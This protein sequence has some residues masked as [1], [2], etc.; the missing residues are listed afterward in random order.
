[1]K[2][3]VIVRVIGAAAAYPSRVASLPDVNL[4]AGAHAADPYFEI[5]YDPQKT[6]R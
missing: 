5:I 4:W 1:M 3:K 6:P 2:V